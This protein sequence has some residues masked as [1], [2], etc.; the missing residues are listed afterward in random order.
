MTVATRPGADST[1]GQ[2]PDLSAAIRAAL[3]HLADLT[4][5]PPAVLD[6]RLDQMLRAALAA[7]AARPT[8]GPGDRHRL[9][10]DE[11]AVAV[12]TACAHLAARELEDAY[13]ALRAAADRLPRV[14]H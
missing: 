6:G 4:Q 8:R 10:M 7:Q 9:A 1:S 13:L 12:R 14:A 2:P 5:P 3:E 11:V